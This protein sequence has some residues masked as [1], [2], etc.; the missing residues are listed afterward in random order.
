MR[1]GPTQV[2]ASR[3]RHDLRIIPHDGASI[4][5]ASASAL[6][7]LSRS[8]GADARLGLLASDAS[9]NRAMSG[10]HVLEATRR[11]DDRV[12]WVPERSI[13]DSRRG[14]AGLED[15]DVPGLLK[16]SDHARSVSAWCSRIPVTWRTSNPEAYSRDGAELVA[17]GRG[18]RSGR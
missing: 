1:S 18:T 4:T 14:L 3:W 15:R 13:L 16:V 12:S 7:A 2:W 11:A 5:Q 17:L 6:V 10:F 8:M 9:V